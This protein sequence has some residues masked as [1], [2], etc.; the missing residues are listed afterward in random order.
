MAQWL[1][2]WLLARPKSLPYQ[3]AGYLPDPLHNLRLIYE[4]MT[5]GVYPRRR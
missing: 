5:M 2:G 1:L 4:W 3:V